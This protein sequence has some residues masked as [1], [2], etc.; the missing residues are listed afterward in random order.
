[1]VVS[2]KYNIGDKVWFISDNKV[3]QTDITGVSIHIG[4]EDPVILYTLH[5]GNEISEDMVF[6]K[7][8]ELLKTL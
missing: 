1:M 5:Y 3:Q 4:K 6:A 8:E 2:S 7:K